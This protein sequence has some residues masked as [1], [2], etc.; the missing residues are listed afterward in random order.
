MLS[1]NIFSSSIS[2][3]PRDFMEMYKYLQLA[4]TIKLLSLC[5]IFFLSSYFPVTTT[6]VL[7]SNHLTEQPS[8]DVHLHYS[9]QNK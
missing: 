3:L 7:V 1:R 6:T 8:S 4:N 9:L 5:M 2:F